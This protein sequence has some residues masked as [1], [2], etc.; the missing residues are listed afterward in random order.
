M[1]PCSGTEIY[2]IR[3][4]RRLSG[5]AERERDAQQWRARLRDRA[6]S[7]PGSSRSSD[8]GLMTFI[9][10]L[11]HTAGLADPGDPQVPPPRSA[12]GRGSHLYAYPSPPLRPRVRCRK[13]C[14][15]LPYLTRGLPISGRIHKRLVCGDEPCRHAKS[16]AAL[17]LFI[18]H[19]RLALPQLPITEQ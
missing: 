19:C 6:P 4:R 12:S 3:A 9:R 14:I 10:D 15:T 5:C 13:A 17:R 2:G 18:V 7:G 16:H 8:D 1:P 11:D